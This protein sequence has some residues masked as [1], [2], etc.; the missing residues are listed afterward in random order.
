MYYFPSIGSE[1][2]QWFT[3]HF[4]ILTLSN[5]VYD[6]LE[7]RK[8]VYFYFVCENSDRKRCSNEQYMQRFMYEKEIYL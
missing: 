4:R 6:I 3:K 2:G 8:R 7:C 5:P 1:S